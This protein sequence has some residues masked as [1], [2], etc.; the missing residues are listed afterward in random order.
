MLTRFRTQLT[1]AMTLIVIATT[2][3]VVFGVIGT[4]FAT[5]GQHITE[6]HRNIAKTV[7]LSIASQPTTPGSGS[8]QSFLT[9]ICRSVPVDSIAVF[10]DVRVIGSASRA[11]TNPPAFSAE[12]I[13]EWR[14]AIAAGVRDDVYVEEIRDGEVILAGTRGADK[15]AITGVAM[16]PINGALSSMLYKRVV[17]VSLFAFLMVLIASAVSALLSRKISKPIGILSESVAR[18]GSGDLRV[19]ARVTGPEELRQL[20]ASVNRMAESLQDYMDDLALETR[21]REQL[22]TEIRVA[23]ELQRSILP[24]DETF[25]ESIELKGMSRQSKEVGG[26]FYDYLALGPSTLGVAIGDAVGKGLPAAILITRCATL[27]RAFAEQGLPPDELLTAVNHVL[28]RQFAKS[29]QF[30]TIFFGIV[31]VHNHRLVYST[32]GHNPPLLIGRHSGEATWLGSAKGL[33]L[34]IEKDVSFGNH[35]VDFTL[36]DV[37]VL[38]TDGV[39]EAQNPQFGLYGSQRLERTAAAATKGDAKSILNAIDT[40]VTQFMEG[41]TVEDDITIVTIKA[42][43]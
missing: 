38:Y 29:G 40:D 13:S 25:F 26:D 18:I 4:G 16:R 31:D 28:C 36:G 17:F 19:R 39:T 35:E 3:A 11:G 15:G 21:R 7:V 27:V 23:S 34:G 37:L 43:A 24:K 6:L 8:V 33:P 9:E 30:V 22:E 10:D 1:L 12:E 41:H 42:N 2:I 14:R 32:A 20:A 5:I